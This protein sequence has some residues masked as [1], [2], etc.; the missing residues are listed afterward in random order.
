[1]GAVRML[2]L[3]VREGDIVAYGDGAISGMVQGPQD[4]G[5]VVQYAW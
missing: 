1:M 5:V 2:L 3:S 4:E